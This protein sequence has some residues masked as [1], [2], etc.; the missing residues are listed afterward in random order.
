MQE[1]CNDAHSIDL[2]RNVP[3]AEPLPPSVG[4][5]KQN[6]FTLFIYFRNVFFYPVQP[7]LPLF[8]VFNRR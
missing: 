5:F 3:K 7:V 6:S 2:A 4:M 1:E 8:I